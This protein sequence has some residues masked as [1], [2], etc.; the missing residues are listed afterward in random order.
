M[1]DQR[2]YEAKY[3]EWEQAQQRYNVLEERFTSGDIMRD[4]MTD[5]LIQQTPEGLTEAFKYKMQELRDAQEDLNRKVL[6]LNASLRDAVSFTPTQ[7]RGWDGRGDTIGIGSFFCTSITKRSFDSKTLLEMA[8][9]Y[10]VEQELLNLTYIDDGGRSR[11]AVEP[12]YRIHYETV[13]NWLLSRGANQKDPRGQ[14][15]DSPYQKILA[16]AYDETE[17][18]P[19]VRG[20]KGVYFLGDKKKE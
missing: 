13:Y 3:Q 14:P 6:E 2:E 17:S 12:T 1:S 15:V 11:L 18:T 4:L 9:K 10:G 16:S 20:P 5:G 7:W 19:Q 8:R